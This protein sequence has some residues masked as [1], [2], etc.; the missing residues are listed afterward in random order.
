MIADR[1]QIDRHRC[2]R[3]VSKFSECK[4]CI[5][6]CPVEVISLSDGAI[7]IDQSSCVECGACISSCPTEA[8]KLS[9]FSPLELFFSLQKEVKPLSCSD[10]ISCLSALSPEYLL[11]YLIYTG[12]DLE[13]E[14][15][16]CQSCYLFSGD[17]GVGKQIS[18]NIEEAN[19]LAEAFNIPNRVIYSQNGKPFDEVEKGRRGI[20]HNLKVNSR[21]VD[22]EITQKIKDGK[23]VSDRRKLLLMAIQKSGLESEHIINSS[24]ISTISE[25]VIDSSCTNCQ[26]CYRICP[27]EA[28][29][30]DYKNSFI[31]FNPSLCVKCNLC[32]DVCQ[33]DS[34]KVKESF[35]LINLSKPKIEKLIEFNIRKCYECDSYFTY[36]GKGAV[37]CHR[38]KIEEEQA[39]DLWGY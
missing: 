39:K 15:G 26:I 38:C 8:L 32:S 19:F 36:S 16:G 22:S 1:V 12:S 5:E 30:T 35:S 14:I 18:R 23:G 4:S 29:T 3:T 33:P 7:K 31:K 6:S 2:T 27:T 28:L 9:K 37:L 13:A 20:L 21:E 34:I 25:K 10:N 17:R 11:S 24:D